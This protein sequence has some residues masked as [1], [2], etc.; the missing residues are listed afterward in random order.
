MASPARDALALGFL[1]SRPPH[2]SHL[3][4][5]CTPHSVV[6]LAGATPTPQTLK[7]FPREGPAGSATAALGQP[8]TTREALGLPAEFAESCSSRM[9]TSPHVHNFC[10]T[11]ASCCA[12]GQLPVSGSQAFLVLP[13]PV[14]ARLGP[15]L[16]AT[17]LPSPTALPPLPAWRLPQCAGEGHRRC[18]TLLRTWI[19]LPLSGG[20]SVSHT[21]T[22]SLRWRLFL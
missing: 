22:D 8:Q 1:H 9:A 7:L 18:N 12:S 5:L 21:H 2:F 15:A 3:S 13:P 19:R 4:G 14:L 16:P 6:T 10:Q 20:R 11:P 17:S